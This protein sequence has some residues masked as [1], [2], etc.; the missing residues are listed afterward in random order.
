MP[1]HRSRFR[2]ISNVHI[3]NVDGGGPHN[4]CTRGDVHHESGIFTTR[5]SLTT[6]KGRMNGESLVRTTNQTSECLQSRSFLP[7]DGRAPTAF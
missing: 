5:L 3:C 4:V 6:S 2:D 1:L 7:L